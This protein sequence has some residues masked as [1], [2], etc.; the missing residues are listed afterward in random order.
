MPAP[1]QTLDLD[2]FGFLLGRAYYSYIGLLQ[3][4]L[5]E[6]SLSAHLKP[7]MGSLLFCLF[8]EDNRTLSEL[9]AE[10][11][12]AKSTMTGMVASMRRAGVLE[13]IPDRVDSRFLRLTLTPLARSLQ[14]KCLELAK[15]LEALLGKNLS[16]TQQKQFRRSLKLVIQAISERL[17]D[18]NEPN[19]AVESQ[20]VSM[21]KRKMR[22]TSKS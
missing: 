4:R 20:P 18:G 17:S 21:A 14:P 3:R 9:A 8:Q 15:E 5:D 19:Q 16:A 1:K 7:G 6:L 2:Q 13:V 22:P 11:Q 12:I 10:L